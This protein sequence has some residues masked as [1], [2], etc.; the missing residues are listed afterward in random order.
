[1]LKLPKKTNSWCNHTSRLRN[2]HRI[3]QHCTART[4]PNKNPTKFK[5]FPDQMELALKHW[6]REPRYNTNLTD[7]GTQIRAGTPT[8]R[9]HCSG[10][11]SETHELEP[12][13]PER[14]RE[15]TPRATRRPAQIRVKPSLPHAAREPAGSALHCPGGRGNSAGA[16]S[17]CE[18]RRKVG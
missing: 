8:P 18:E 5:V 10:A 13:P 16:Q 12:P 4:A 11:S 1:M 7:T 3:V 9:R 17:E 6:F 14:R 15:Q 2:R